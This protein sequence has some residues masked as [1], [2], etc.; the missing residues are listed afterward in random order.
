MLVL[1]LAAGSVLL[2]AAIAA[3]MVRLP[4]GGIRPGPARNAREGREL[5]DSQGL[6]CQSRSS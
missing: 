3:A 2:A 1:P 6:N 5:I 4:A